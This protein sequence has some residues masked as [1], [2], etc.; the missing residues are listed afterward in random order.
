[1]FVCQGAWKSLGERTYGLTHP[2]FNYLAPNGQLDTGSSV[3]AELTLAR[4]MG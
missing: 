1:M 3:G 4:P 2:A